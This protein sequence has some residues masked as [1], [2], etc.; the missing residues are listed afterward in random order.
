MRITARTQ[1]ATIAPFEK[2]FTAQTIDALK[3]SAEKVCGNMYDLSF[4]TFWACQNGDFSHLNMDVSNPTALQV[5]WIKRFG[6]FAVDFAKQLQA[7]TLQPTA[8]EQAANN[9]L[10]RVD[11]AEAMLVFLQSWFGLKSYKEAEKIT[12]GELLIA[13]RAQYNRDKFQRNF[14]AIQRKKI[15][16]K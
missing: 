10:L 9:G 1:Y 8:D 14:A 11:F 6:E 3:A 4:A 5:Y 2:Y 7:Y 15:K 13:K 16:T 12:L